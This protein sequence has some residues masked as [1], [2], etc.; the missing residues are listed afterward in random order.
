MILG[1]KF[2]TVT[3]MSLEAI[4]QK[5]QK[6]AQG[7]FAVFDFDNTLII[8]DTGEAVL[9]YLA[10]NGL[11]KDTQLLPG[12]FAN[13]KSYG[14]AV[15]SHYHDLL[16]KNE[17]WQAYQFCTKVLSGFTPAQVG[18]ITR[19]TLEFE[20][21]Q[22]TEEELF[23]RKIHRGIMPRQNATELLKMAANEGITNWVVTSS[24]QLAVKAAMD[25][26]GIKANIIGVCNVENNGVLTQE[27][28]TPTPIREDK[29][30]AIKAFIDPK[31]PPVLA[32]GDSMNDQWMLEYA[33][34][35]AV[36]GNNEK[37][38]TLAKE[39]GWQV[40]R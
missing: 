16:D 4:Q 34:E 5:L 28:K 2:V 35:R 40:L 38:I 33:R 22:I 26:F 3:L 39:K 14:Q 12:E 37:L 23:G 21:T 20:G 27:L 32:V 9:M 1:N 18:E 24:P 30:T 36:V 8:S 11:F 17:I 25:Y 7:S 31:I 19:Q 6:T 13:A 29:V 15:F 10:R